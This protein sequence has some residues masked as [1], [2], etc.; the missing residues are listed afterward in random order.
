MGPRAKRARFARDESKSLSG[1]SSR[2]RNKT[3]LAVVPAK[4]F[5]RFRDLP[6]ELRRMIWD[7][8]MPGTFIEAKYY[9]A[10]GQFQSSSSTL[11]A[12]ASSVLTPTVF[13]LYLTLNPGLSILSRI[14]SI[15][16]SI[17]QRLDGVAVAENTSPAIEPLYIQSR[18]IIYLPDIAALDVDALLA[19]TENH[20]IEHL[21]LPPIEVPL[22]GSSQWFKSTAVGNCC[23]VSKI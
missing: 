1:P 19:R 5:P 16:S 6:I 21:A 8:A 9:F 22:S 18:D 13:P 3:E 2:T 23:A 12:S 14:Q 10:K 4:R 17:I 7:F 15:L 11:P 20:V